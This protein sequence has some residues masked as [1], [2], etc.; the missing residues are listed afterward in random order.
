[1]SLLEGKVGVMT[2]GTILHWTLASGWKVAHQI[3]IMVVVNQME[4][5][6][7]HKM[8]LKVA[9]PELVYQTF[10]FRFFRGYI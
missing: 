7:V 4:W 2:I 10:L 6:V 5:K 1:M 3:W 9:H 8:G